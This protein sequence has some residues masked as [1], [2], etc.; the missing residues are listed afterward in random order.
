MAITIS[1]DGTPVETQPDELLANVLSKHG[2]AIRHHRLDGTPREPFCMMGVCFECV[3]TI[4][5]EPNQQ[6][7][8]TL[9]RDGMVVE[10]G[11]V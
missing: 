4:D 7:C 10:R 9:V 2:G 8:L 5:G 11:T 6:A 3:V 1:V